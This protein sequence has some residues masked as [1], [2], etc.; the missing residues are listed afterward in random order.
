M[1]PRVIHTAQAL[2]DAVMEVPRLPHRGGNVMATSYRRYAGGAVNVL[3]AAAQC[4][5]NPFDDV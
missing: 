2:V 5:L 4:L 1:A 3:L